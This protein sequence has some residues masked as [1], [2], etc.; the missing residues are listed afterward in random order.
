M[1]PALFAGVQLVYDMVY[2]AQ[3]TPFLQQ[4]AAHG[5]PVRDGLGMLVE[6]AALAFAWWRGVEPDGRAVLQALRAELGA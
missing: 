5:A 1:P 4:A 2:G 3:L 6:Q